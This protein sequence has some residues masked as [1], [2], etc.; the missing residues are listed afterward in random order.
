MARTRG[1][2]ARRLRALGDRSRGVPELLRAHTGQA[3]RQVLAYAEKRLL[4][5]LEGP[6]TTVWYDPREVGPEDREWVLTRC[7]SA[8]RKICARLDLSSESSVSVFLY[9]KR[10]E[11][12]LWNALPLLG[13][14][15]PDEVHVYFD[16]PS[17]HGPILHEMTHVLT[18][19]LATFGGN[20]PPPALLVEGL[21]EY[22]VGAPWGI[23]VDVW[24]RGVDLLGRRVA[25]TTL[26][27]SQ[28]FR[29]ANPVVAYELAGSFVRFLI[30]RFGLEAFKRLYSHPDFLEVYGQQLAVLEGRWLERL[31]GI[32]PAEREMGWIRYRTLLADAWDARRGPEEFAWLG[33]D[34]AEDSLKGVRVVRVWPESPAMREGLRAGDRILEVDGMAVPKGGSWVL[35]TALLAK[36]PGDQIALVLDRGTAKV[37]MTVR[38]DSEMARGGR[39]A[40]RA[41]N[42]H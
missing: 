15:R 26:A 11:P 23:D 5:K 33:V 41:H 19:S 9:P 1:E 27:D 3:Y 25:V 10:M 31:R 20:G 29:R 14:L 34:V 2:R 40:K 4:G 32:E 13:R 24:S 16:S 6:R 38:T 39:M 21:A 8:Y 37:H 12:L 42:D 7:E 35:A 18:R 17:D 36:T 28:A 22:V 30:E